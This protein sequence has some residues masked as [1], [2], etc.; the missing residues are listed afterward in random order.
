MFPENVLPA[1]K[2]PS[3]LIIVVAPTLYSFAVTVPVPIDMFLFES[4]IDVPEI[5]I[6]DPDTAPVDV[7]AVPVIVPAV[8]VRVS[9]VKFP[10]ESI[11]VVAPIL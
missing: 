2:F 6:Y 10:D 7:K 8:I 11:N 1:G 4:I 5:L 3:E 9:N